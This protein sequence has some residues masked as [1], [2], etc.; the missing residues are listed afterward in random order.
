ME[1]NQNDNGDHGNVEVEGREQSREGP[2]DLARV[3]LWLRFF[4]FVIDGVL[5]NIAIVLTAGGLVSSTAP[6]AGGSAM[7]VAL[8]SWGV[9]GVYYVAFETIIGQT[10]GK[11]LTGTMVVSDQGTP[12][13]FGTA[14][15]RT[16]LRIV[17]FEPIFGWVTGQFWHDTWSHTRVVKKTERLLRQTTHAEAAAPHKLGGLSTMRLPVENAQKPPHLA[18]GREQETGNR[19]TSP[20][21]ALQKVRRPDKDINSGTRADDRNGT[22]EEGP[23]SCSACKAN[24]R[25]GARTCEWCGAPVK[26]EDPRA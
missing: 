6:S 2:S 15:L 13:G 18:G 25:P 22:T 23:A 12:I 10:P 21:E 9:W 11:M 16:I 7:A 24:L 17:P 5:L 8:V 4:N 19:E 3:S 20:I 14:A 26:K 1:K